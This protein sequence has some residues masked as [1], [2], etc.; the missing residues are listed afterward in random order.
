MKSESAEHRY[1]RYAAE[2]ELNAVQAAKAV[3]RLAWQRLAEDWTK[4]ARACE[5]NPRDNIDSRNVDA[6]AAG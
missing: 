6:V 5:V 1:R 3:D 2:C 4:L